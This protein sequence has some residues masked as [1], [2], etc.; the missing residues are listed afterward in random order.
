MRYGPE[1]RG[2]D[3][4]AAENRDDYH[5]DV[6]ASRGVAAGIMGAVNAARPGVR[7]NYDRAAESLDATDSQ[8]AEF[9]GLT[10]LFASAAARESAGA[11]RRLA[12]ERAGALTDLASRK[13]QAQEGRAYAVANAGTRYHEQQGKIDRQRQ[14]LK[15][16]MAAFRLSTYQQLTADDHK[17]RMEEKRLRISEQAERRQERSTEADITGI[18]PLTGL[19]TAGER[20]RRHD[21]NRQDRKDAADERYRSRHGGRSRG[22]ISQHQGIVSAV[23]DARADAQG[24]RG[25]G[26][27]WSE[28]RAGL[29]APK[30]EDNPY[31]GHGPI[32]SQAGVEL[33]RYGH[34]R[35]STARALR[36]RGFLPGRAPNSWRQTPRGP[37]AVPRNR[38]GTPG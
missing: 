10:G 34:L 28:I 8:L 21:N 29:R 31:G 30:S 4:L 32:V 20:D 3:E 1:I 11:D 26:A 24:A 19:P 13:V 36:A 22:E 15:G 37:S 25:I 33:A 27:H 17:T 9:G 16:D 35:E 2:L 6:D 7:Q 38:D 18:D 14:G 5:F 23:Q 12:D